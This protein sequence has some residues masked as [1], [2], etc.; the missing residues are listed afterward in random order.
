MKPLDPLAK[1]LSLDEFAPVQSAAKGRLSTRRKRILVGVVV[2]LVVAASAG[3]A[4]SRLLAPPEQPMQTAEVT[5]GTFEETVSGK[6]TL[7]PVRTTI[8]SPE[9]EGIVESVNVGEGAAVNEGD[10][11]YTLKN[12]DLDLAVAQANA[13]LQSA[14]DALTQAN[15]KLKLARTTPSFSE[16]QDAQGNPVIVNTQPSQISDAESR[17]IPPNPPSTP[18]RAPTTP[19]WRRPRSAPSARTWRARCWPATSLR[20]PP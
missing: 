18:R 4:A 8:A 17:S 20:E 19:P 13:Q 15:N 6:G 16:G 14:R 2:G 1:P 5:Q 7:E 10:V 9:V 11:L 12:D 3:F